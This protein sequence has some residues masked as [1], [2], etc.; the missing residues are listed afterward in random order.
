MKNFYTSVFMMLLPFLMQSQ[1]DNKVKLKQINIVKTNFRDSKSGEII[2]KTVLFKEGKL[3]SIQ[4]S[5]VFQKFFYNTHGLLD[6]TVKDKVGS[7]WKEVVNYVYDNENRLIKFVKKYQEEGQFVIKKI[8]VSYDGPRV[9]AITTKSS[10]HQDSVEN[11]EY[12]VENG[13]IVRRSSRDR[14]QQIIKK[15]EYVYS[16]D[17]IVTHK[18]LVGDKSMQNYVFDDKNSADLLIVQNL[19]GPNYKVIVPLVSFHEEEFDFESIS[20]N[21]LLAYSSNS[22]KYVGKTGKYKYNSM[23]YPT[24]HSLI[25]ENGIVKTEMT[26]LY[27][28]DNINF[29]TK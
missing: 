5:D 7:N 10:D 25:E 2:N 15:T 26:Y 27:E 13:I 11:I 22:S 3:Q 21:N 16:K 14:N 20:N 9:K 12:I 4:T 23:N 1:M 24:S 19:F 18:G 8:D 28:F 29:G 17:N 6:M